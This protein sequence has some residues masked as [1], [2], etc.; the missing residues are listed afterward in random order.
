MKTKAVRMYAQRDLRLDEYDLDPMGEDE[1]LAE[2]VTDS[3]C[4]STYKAAIQGSRHKRVPE[5][6]DKRP[7]VIGHEFAGRILEVGE[8]WKDRY[9]PGESFT[10]QP[11]IN[12]LNKGY[13]PGYSFNQFGG[14]ATR[15][16]IPGIVMEKDCLLS[17]KG[18]AY[19]KASL[20]EPISCLIAAYKASYHTPDGKNHQTGIRP[21]GNLAILAGCGPMGLGAIDLAINMDVRP[22]VIVVT[23]IDAK[24][25]E[26]A[27]QILPPEKAAQNGVKLYYVNTRDMENP[28][29]EL[30]KFTKEGKGFDDVFI[31]AP[32]ASVVETGVAIAAQDA[33]INFFSG[34]TDSKFSA[35]VNFYDI[36][37]KGCHYM[38]TSGGDA[39]DLR[40]AVAMIESRRINPA[41]MVSHIGGLNAAADATLNL[42]QIPGGKK[43][44][45]TNL[46]MELVAI[47]DF[48]EKGKT[49]PMFK[50]LAEICIRHNMLW[51]AEAE[52]YLLENAQR[53]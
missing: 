6:I 45:Y 50:T 20:A 1:I 44:I 26:R 3:I 21:K 35:M 17:Y 12:Y 22:D 8:R 43:L 52:K 9:K 15:I 24:R 47:E 36:H 32:V 28:A 49:D 27:Q 13:A 4:M 37:Y 18:D 5:D 14:D 46:N 38:G 2:I 10:I 39:E 33:C 42:P 29:A 34:P 41:V 31:L 16:L 40:D 23:D 30:T 48:A 53:I 51:S 25:L 19:F 7:I 11:N